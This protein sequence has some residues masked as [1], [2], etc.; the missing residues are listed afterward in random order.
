M[1]QNCFVT[2][3]R[4]FRTNPYQWLNFTDSVNNS[5]IN[6]FILVCTSSSSS[7]LL[8]IIPFSYLCARRSSYHSSCIQW[9]ISRVILQSTCQAECQVTFASSC[10]TSNDRMIW[11]GLYEFKKGVKKWLRRTFCGLNI[12]LLFEHRDWRKQR[13]ASIYIPSLQ[14]ETFIPVL[15]E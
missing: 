5:R 8:R 13:N 10:T 4:R 15:T 9:R 7:A 3:K 1:M 11:G 6:W 2:K 14:A 12:T